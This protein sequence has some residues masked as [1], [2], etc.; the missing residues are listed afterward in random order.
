MRTCRVPKCF[1]DLVA[2]IQTDHYTQLPFNNYISDHIPIKNGTTQG[3][4]QSMLYYAL[5]NAPLIEI[6]RGLFE[7]SPGFVDDSIYDAGYH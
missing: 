6:A 4:P 1:I 5:Y 2:H 7:L 3:D